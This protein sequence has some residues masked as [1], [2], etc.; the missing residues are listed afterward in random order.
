MPGKWPPKCVFHNTKRKKQI[1]ESKSSIVNVKRNRNMNSNCRRMRIELKKK[2]S[3]HL[4]R[5]QSEYSNFDLNIR[6]S[7]G[8]DMA[9]TRQT[10]KTSFTN[11]KYNNSRDRLG[12]DCVSDCLF[13]R[14]DSLRGIA[15]LRCPYVRLCVCL[16]S[17][18]FNFKYWHQSSQ[19]SWHFVI[20]SMSISFIM[21]T[22]FMMTKAC[23]HVPVSVTVKV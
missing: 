6:D 9:S 3:H 15:T 4:Q 11:E 22:K 18:Q 20:M 7:T 12:I 21:Y 8:S 10:H 17:L 1:S 14:T 19:S 13:S 5:V 2:S 23:L 16:W